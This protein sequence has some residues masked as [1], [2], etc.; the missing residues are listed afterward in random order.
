MP[1]LVAPCKP[2][3]SLRLT[4]LLHGNSAI[5]PAFRKAGALRKSPDALLSV[6]TNR[7]E[8]EN[9]FG[10]Q[11]HGVGPCSEGWLKSWRKSVLQSTRSTT[12]CPALGEYPAMGIR[13]VCPRCQSLK[14]K[15][16]PKDFP[17]YIQRSVDEV[18]EK[19]T[20]SNTFWGGDE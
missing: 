16:R 9:T 19:R 17:E 12:G 1:P 15:K 11:S 2:P 4:V 18:S 20:L 8:N 7:V 10:P 6:F 3:H 5:T 13:D 14:F